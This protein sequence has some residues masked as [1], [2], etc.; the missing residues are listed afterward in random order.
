MIKILSPRASQSARAVAEECV[1]Q[2]TY[3]GPISQQ[4]RS[5]AGATFLI[6]WGLQG[7]SKR[8]YYAR[9]PEAR[10][11]PTMNS[12][13]PGN[14]YR[15]NRALHEAGIPVPD[16]RD[17]IAAVPEGESWIYKPFFSRGGNNIG[18]I[19][20]ENIASM[21]WDIGYAQ[22]EVENRRYELRVSAFSWL[23]VEEWGIWKKVNEHPENL[24]W[25]HEQGGTFETVQSRT[26]PLFVR[27]MEH[28]KRMM[29]MFNLQF[30]AVDFIIGPESNEMVLEINLRP[31][32]DELGKPCYVNAMNKLKALSLEEQIALLQPVEV[33]PVQDDTPVVQ[34]PFIRPEDL[35]RPSM[36][37]P[38]ENYEN[39]VRAALE[40]FMRA[41]VTRRQ[42]V[43][44]ANNL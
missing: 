41:G 35:E 44:I 19:T 8:Q 24:T 2:R 40:G 29:A 30:C 32:F 3:N 17:H 14:K 1:I 22:K 36:P 6:N 12:E 7:L 10:N 34:R 37:T 21:R 20:D 13:Y 43:N 42:L 31:G 16:T 27:C 5:P 23:P 38:P 11:I 25:N 28:T 39:L 33:T 18:R 4:R 26:A 15:V 9:Y